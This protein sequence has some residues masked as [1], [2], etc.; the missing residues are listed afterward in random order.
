MTSLGADPD[1]LEA[2]AGKLDAGAR[3]IEEQIRSMPPELRAVWWVGSL[4]T[5]FSQL[6]TQR[7]T[8]SVLNA[9]AFLQ[10][11]A[12]ELRKQ[13][14]EQRA[15]SASGGSRGGGGPGVQVT[16][17]L[18]R[19]L[20]EARRLSHEA[21]AAWWQGLT[22]SEQDALL[23]QRPGELTGL[24]GLPADVLEAARDK[25]FESISNEVVVGESTA[26]GH[27]GWDKVIVLEVG[28]E[29]RQ[30]TFAD[31]SVALTLVIESAVGV[32][33]S[34]ALSLTAEGSN[35]ATFR[36]RN[37]READDFL[38]G[39]TQSLK[40]SL[41]DLIPFSGGP[42]GRLT[43]FL[44]SHSSNLES[45][46]GGLG[47]DGEVKVPGAGIEE[48]V[49]VTASVTGAGSAEGAGTLI[50][51][52]KHHVEGK[53]HTAVVGADGAVDIS[54]SASFDGG[55]MESLSLD[56]SVE[57]ASLTGVWAGEVAS[58]AGGV[59]QASSI[60]IELDLTDPQVSG[61]QERLAQLIRVG[62][63]EA[64][65]RELEKVPDRCAV[66]IQ[67]DVG[68]RAQGSLDAG[69]EGE[70]QFQTT[71]NDVTFVRAPGGGFYVVK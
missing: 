26:E 46:E 22:T 59:V 2:A 6:L 14:A 39:L 10:G 9:A 7:H 41:S 37:Q 8:P 16:P 68:V 30:K 34:K 60:H 1:Q 54:A 33:L 31:G 61:I 42:A 40:P 28:F 51:E 20:Q 15:A 12:R 43:E 50:L 70:I 67:G 69:L 36:F 57:G 65:V 63:V 25:Y 44:L 66:V 23:A 47:L 49:N 5:Q 3:E 38:A 32:G 48:G 13:A 24:L 21:Q 71:A 45:L 11:M 35:G 19:Q 53:F 62:D 55:K 56:L 17:Q 58:L 29:A 27:F 52:A 18:D 64:V 4:A